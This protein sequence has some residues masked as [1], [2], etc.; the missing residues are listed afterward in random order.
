MNSGYSYNSVDYDWKISMHTIQPKLRQ[1]MRKL[2]AKYFYSYNAGINWMAPLF[3][4]AGIL[5]CSGQTNIYT[6]FWNE[7]AFSRPLK[8]KKAFEVNIGQT[9]TSTPANNSMLAT[10]SQLYLRVWGHYYQSSRWKLS[11]FM[12]YY[13]NKDVP[14]INQKKLPELRTA[15]QA[16]YFFK[17][18][19]YTLNARFRIEDRKIQRSQQDEKIWE[20]S[21]RGRAQLRCLYPI[22]NKLIKDG[23]FYMLASDEFFFKTGSL[24]AGSQFFDRN[25]L[26]LGGGYAFTDDFQ[27][28]LSYANEFLPRGSETEIYNAFQIN[29]AF[30]NFF[31]NLKKKHFKQKEI[32]PVNNE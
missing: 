27:L 18:V 1:A 13:F 32:M 19:P 4:F 17:K 25:R 31:P 22:N 12:A 5:P 15:I 30:N 16:M 14:E 9:W 3:F 21:Y 29:M 2:K 8:G 28:E 23:T 7:F 24:L 11:A 26:T 20:A 6:Q 10:N